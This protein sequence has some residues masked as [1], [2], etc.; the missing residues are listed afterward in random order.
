M[1]LIIY[2]NL[3]VGAHVRSN[4]CYLIKLMFFKK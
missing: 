1:V 3:E 2:G 4:I